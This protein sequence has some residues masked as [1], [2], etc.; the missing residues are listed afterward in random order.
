MRSWNGYKLIDYFF[1]PFSVD[2]L[3]FGTANKQKITGKEAKTKEKVIL[4]AFINK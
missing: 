4:C 3:R 1:H 2:F